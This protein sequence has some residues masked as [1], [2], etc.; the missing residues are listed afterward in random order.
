[1]NPVGRV[2]KILVADDDPGSLELLSEILESEGYQIIPAEN[3]TEALEVILHQDLDLA[4]LD[5]ILPDWN[6]FYLCRIAKANPKTCL[7][8]I[9]L[10]TS[11]TSLDDRIEG[12][13]AGA[14]DFLSKPVN[15]P[16]LLARVRALLKLKY[17]TDELEH[18][19]SVVLS[20]AYSI[21]GR[22]PYTHGHCDRLSRYSV[23]L[24]ERLELPEEQKVALRRAGIV[25][26]IGKVVVPDQILMKT[27]PLTKEERKSMQQHPIVGERICAPLRTFH[28]V[29]PIIRHHHE[30]MD[31]S[32]YPD[33]LIGEE[34]PLTARI[35]ATVDVYD[36]LTTDRPYRAALRPREAL[37]IMHWEVREGWLDRVLVDV[38]E[39]IIMEMLPE[40]VRQS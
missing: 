21:E 24:A 40:S 14:D 26:D 39:S 12:I 10:V 23:A 20:L 6:G 11:L 2:S 8:P 30:R 35:L 38:F 33:G 4:L 1:M 3:G 34:I 31:G 25:H 7:T 32:G 28:Y 19:E 9:V 36:A 29:L 27:S 13:Q 16:E 18:A 22:D 15:R 5:V 37:A 17:Y